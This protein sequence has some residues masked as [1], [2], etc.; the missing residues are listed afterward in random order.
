MRVLLFT[1][2]VFLSASLL[3]IVEPMVGK[4]ILPMLGGT[5]AVWN[6]CLV[7]F[8]IMLL[9]GYAYVHLMTRALPPRA[10]VLL[11]AIVLTSAIICLPLSIRA[12]SPPPTHSNPIG[13]LLV[14]LVV[15]IGLPFAIVSATAPLVQKWFAYSGSDGSEK[16]NDPYFLYAA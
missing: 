4:M 3:F 12:W 11:H 13:W 9:A 15:S 1:A 10:Q 8:Q 14:V 2:T 6:T 7:F 16:S 5:P